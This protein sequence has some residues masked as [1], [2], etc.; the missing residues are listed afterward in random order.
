MKRTT[1]VLEDGCIDAVRELAQRQGR[2]LSEVVNELLTE[3]LQRRRESEEQPPFVLP[4]F[5]MGP[6]RVDV[7]DRDALEAAME[8]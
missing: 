1:L 6:P 3:G 2:Q 4:S 5:R 7:A 8:G